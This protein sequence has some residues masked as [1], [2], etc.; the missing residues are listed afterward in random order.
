MTPLY[1]NQTEALPLPGMVSFGGTMLILLSGL[2]G[3][4][5]S[6]IAD[7]IGRARQIPVFSV[8]PIESAIILGGIPASFETGL[9]AYLVARTLADRSLDI[10]LDAVI[11]AVNSMDQARD[12][13]RELAAKHAV[14]LGIIECVVS[15]ERVHQTRVA[16]RER[17]LALA[18]PSWDDVERRR[19][20]WTPW[21]E[22][23]L[24]LDAVDSSGFNL[25]R[26]LAYVERPPS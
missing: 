19:L 12:M 5:K 6:T 13:W 3:T 17:G 2:P 1:P 20:E 16:S 9:A 10:G 7:G 14:E 21:P 11:D 25:A 15:D 24:T 4:G 23:H 8:D 22:R 18:E 26:A